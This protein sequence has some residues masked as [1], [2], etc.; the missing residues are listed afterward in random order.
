MT[1]VV[2]RWLEEKPRYMATHPTH[3]AHN[4]NPM[5]TKSKS[6]ALASVE[7]R[8][9]QTSGSLLYLPRDRKASL[10][11]RARPSHAFEGERRREL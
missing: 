4:P 3:R 5:E 9:W 2:R 11:W 1:S 8:A 7:I 10:G 6:S